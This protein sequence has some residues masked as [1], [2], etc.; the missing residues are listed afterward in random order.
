MRPAFFVFFVLAAL[1]CEYNHT[2]MTNG[3]CDVKDAAVDLPW[4]KERIKDIES[5]SLKEY[6]YIS[7]ATYKGKT[8]IIQGN[9]CPMCNTVIPVTNCAGELLF[10]ADDTKSKDLKNITVIWRPEPFACTF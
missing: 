7:R 10:Y 5:S 2:S 4:L 9:C 3:Y 6:F 1:S 8:V